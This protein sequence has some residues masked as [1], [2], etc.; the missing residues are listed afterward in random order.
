MDTPTDRR[1]LLGSSMSVL[2][3]WVNNNHQTYEHKVLLKLYDDK[4]NN[5]TNFRLNEVNTLI[6]ILECPIKEGDQ[7]MTSQNDYQDGDPFEVGGIPNADSTLTLH[8]ISFRPDLP[9][10]QIK[11]VKS[12]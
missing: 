9:I 10:N 8:V 11:Q 4:I 12:I 3:P 5:S 2:Q 6:G 1:T 7:I